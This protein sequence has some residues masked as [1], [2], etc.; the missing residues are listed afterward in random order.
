MRGL[1]G[2]TGPVGPQGPKGDKGDTGATGPVGQQ[3]PV[4]P[5]GA[6]G[7]E[8][9]QGLRGATGSTG[10]TGPVGPQGATPTLDLKLEGNN[11]SLVVNGVADTVTLP[12]G[13]GTPPTITNLSASSFA[14][15]WGNY[16]KHLGY[17]DVGGTRY[18]IDKVGR[19]AG[20]NWLVFGSTTYN[21]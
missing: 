9:P 16:S 7:Q 17:F 2:A 19:I 15:P 21:P 5:R 20:T 4:G 18:T 10:P 3:G 13:G 11:L 14:D 8:G 12:T 1:T 6:P